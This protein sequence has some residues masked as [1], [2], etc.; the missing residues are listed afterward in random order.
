MVCINEF[1]SCTQ[2]PDESLAKFAARI[3]NLGELAYPDVANPEPYLIQQLVSGAHATSIQKNI[4]S[5]HACVTLNDALN[6][7][8]EVVNVN[9]LNAEVFKWPVLPNVVTLSRRH[10]VIGAIALAMC[11]TNATHVP[12]RTETQ[13]DRDGR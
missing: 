13:Q 7:I 2:R 8:A 3:R 10:D 6:K 5:S 1:H 12:R 11:S 9:D 4:V